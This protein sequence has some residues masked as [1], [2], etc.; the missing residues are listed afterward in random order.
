MIERLQGWMEEAEVEV[1]CLT[2]PS[3]IAYLT[4][5][6]SNP[7]ERLMALVV[8]SDRAALLLPAIEEESARAQ[9]PEIE[10]KGWSDGDDPWEEL[11][12]LTGH[13]LTGLAVEKDHLTLSG[14][15]KLSSQVQF[16]RV[17]DISAPLRQWRAIKTPS[18]LEKLSKAAQIT[19]QLFDQLLAILQPGITELE[20][21]IYLS[22]LTAKFGT[23]PS[24]PTLVQFGPHS[25]E[26][27]GVTSNQKLIPGQLILLDFGAAY[28]GYCADTTRMVVLGESDPKQREIHQIVLEAH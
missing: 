28:Q 16:G 7:F 10:L 3:S 18:E 19:D 17:S 5:F 8:S 24:F 1:A 14:Y 4:G 12:R 22:E 27:H 11:A 26:P 9:A 2:N 21:G 6:R 20:V 23:K 15:E 13:R 25:A